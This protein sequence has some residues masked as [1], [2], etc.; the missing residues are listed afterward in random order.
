[1][2]IFS[3]MTQDEISSTSYI[4]SARLGVILPP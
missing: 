3:D 4:Y 2:N 1:V